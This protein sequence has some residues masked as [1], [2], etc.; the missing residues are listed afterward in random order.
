M[1]MKSTSF[2]AVIVCSLIVFGAL[3]ARA[4]GQRITFDDAV[5]IALDRNVELKKAENDVGLAR[6]AVSG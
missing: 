4:Q 1:T 2:V 5:S 3:E 6:R